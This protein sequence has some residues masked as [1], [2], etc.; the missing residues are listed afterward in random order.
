[1]SDFESSIYEN[2]TVLMYE[3][4]YGF[5]KKP[6]E[7]VPNPE[8]LYLSKAHR[9]AL[10][11]LE[12]GL[13][14]RAGFI[15]LTGEIG[16]GKTTIVRSLLNRLEAKT[17][18]ASIFNTKA[19]V[20]QLLFMINE[21]FGISSRAKDKMAMLSD[22][23]E[24]L[25]QKFANNEKPVLIIDEA[26]NLTPDCLEEVRLLSNLESNNEKLL[27]IILVG[28]PDLKA[29]IAQPGLQQLRQRI[30]V[31]FHLGVLSTNETQEYF[32]HRV[33]CAGNANAIV[34]PEGCFELIHK[35]SG[36]VPRL[37]NV[38][39]DYLLLA[40]FS[41]ETQAPDLDMVM[42]VI[43][44]L[45]GN[46]AF[47]DVKNNGN[48]NDR[49]NAG[50]LSCPFKPILTTSDWYEANTYSLNGIASRLFR[51]EKILK[52]IVETGF[53]QNLATRDRLEKIN[54]TMNYIEETLK[55]L[56]RSHFVTRA[57][58]L[59][60]KQ[61]EERIRILQLEISQQTKTYTEN[62][63]GISMLKAELDA[64]LSCRRKKDEI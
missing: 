25:V 15:L 30:S 13:T 64:L 31:D 48:C 29:V 18:P 7:L 14:S 57:S 1:M 4:F 3:K 24:F 43:N 46:I 2:G 23:N 22:L 58:L 56:S 59:T 62:Y 54:L 55:H 34:F 37:I 35:A 39:G 6:F 49:A 60:V 12:Y 36:G 11:F 38:I 40:G 21:D 32:L 28:Q 50:N 9:K 42:E 5:N 44:D 27:Q 19:D 20:N 8:F 47:Y 53:S 17:V 33:G 45:Q 61:R 63:P 52:Q 26:Q 10:N 16:S 51:H 41:E